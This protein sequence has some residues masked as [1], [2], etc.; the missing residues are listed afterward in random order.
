MDDVV[1]DVEMAVEMQGDFADG[2][3]LAHAM[4]GEALRHVVSYTLGCPG[5]TVAVLGAMF[6]LSIEAAER[7]N[8]TFVNGTVSSTLDPDTVSY[9]ERQV[10]LNQHREEMRPRLEYYLREAKK[11]GANV[12]IEDPPDMGSALN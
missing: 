4:I 1:M 8:Q 3:A 12:H 2:L 6:D 7:V 5:C 10:L 9:A 11:R